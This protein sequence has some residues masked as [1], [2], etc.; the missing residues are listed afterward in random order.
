MA[1]LA[2]IDPA[3]LERAAWMVLALGGAGGLLALALLRALASLVAAFGGAVVA[4]LARISAA[5][6]RAA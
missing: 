4:P 2:V 3:D 6:R 1:P 5:R